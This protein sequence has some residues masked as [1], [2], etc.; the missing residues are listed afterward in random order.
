MAYYKNTYLPFFSEQL[1]F[2]IALYTRTIHLLL[3]VVVI[4]VLFGCVCDRERERE[5]DSCAYLL[6]SLGICYGSKY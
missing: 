2:I 6:R 5:A 3:L 4:V 1:L